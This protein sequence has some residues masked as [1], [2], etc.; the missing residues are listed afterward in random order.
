MPFTFLVRSLAD[1]GEF[2]LIQD[3][4]KT[5]GQ[6][7]RSVIKGIGDD[8]ALLRPHPGQAFL[9][10]TDLL[11]EG[12]HFD[13]NLESFE[14]VGYRA[15]VANLSDIAAMGGI[16]QYLLVAIAVPG[17]HTSSELSAF[18]RGLMAPCQQHGVE[19]VGGDTSSSHQGIFLSITLIGRIDPKLAI[20]RKRA[21]VGDLI[22]VTGTLGDS[23]SGLKILQ[24]TATKRSRRGTKTQRSKME[25]FLINRH[26]RPT[27]RMQ[28]GRL[29]A[30][31][32]LATAAIDISDGLS[33]D[34]IHICRESRVG[35]ELEAEALP[36]SESCRVY[37]MQHGARSL[38]LA[39]T[40]GE[41]YELL[42]TVSPRKQ[43][44]LERLIRGVGIQVTRIGMIR[45]KQ[46]GMRLRFAT[47]RSRQLN[48]DSYQHFRR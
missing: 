47:G 21:Q 8:A 43:R 38:D 23:L 15:A 44:K 22:Y 7:G 3:I 34:L 33:G 31:H 27:P 18:Y 12:I 1:L 41:D 42:F 46:S 20:G 32:R 25:R 39:L 6:T 13:L 24:A 48:E 11:V 45:P 5:F 19:L 40:G 16:P 37:A 2:N 28:V 14:D 26:L 36:I 4:R 35:A 9:V 17:R 29:L 10:T 30:E